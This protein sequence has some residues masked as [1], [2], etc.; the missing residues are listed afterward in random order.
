MYNVQV[1]HNILWSRYKAKVFSE[2]YKKSCNSGID[3]SFVQ[4]A[5]TESGR[6]SIPCLD[7]SSH[8]YKYKL[9]FNGNYS[10][11]PVVRRVYGLFMVSFNTFC[12]IFNRQVH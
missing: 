6:S 1:F 3:Y 10:E 7:I 4:I 2:I 8:N 9:L 12:R 11:V 5:E